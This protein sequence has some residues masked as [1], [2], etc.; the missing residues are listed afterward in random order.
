MHLG[1]HFLHSL[2]F[3]FV[4]VFCCNTLLYL[5]GITF[6]CSDMSENKLTAIPP[7]IGSM[8]SLGRLD[9]HS[10]SIASLPEEIGQLKQV[11]KFAD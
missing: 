4:P 8:T 7:C 6:I 9:L 10:N 3:A 5:I 1:C 11:P 2:L